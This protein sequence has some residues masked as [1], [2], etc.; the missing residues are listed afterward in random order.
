[1]VRKSLL[2]QACLCTMSAEI[3]SVSK[4]SI[5]LVVQ[6]SLL[7]NQRVSA[8]ISTDSNSSCVNI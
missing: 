3:S 6:K 1:M 7:N 2:L 8:E 5:G 4:S